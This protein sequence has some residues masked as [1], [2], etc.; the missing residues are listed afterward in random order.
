MIEIYLFLS[1]FLGMITGV[2]GGILR[3][4][5]SNKTPD[6]FVKKIYA[7]ATIIGALMTALLWKWY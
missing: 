1:V 2:G 4:L 7:C 6:I 3:D 5:F